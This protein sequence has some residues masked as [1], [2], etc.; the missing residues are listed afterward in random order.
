MIFLNISPL[1]FRPT[2][3]EIDLNA[4][5]HN[6][7]EF[8][9]IL[10][11]GVKIMAVVKADAYGHGAVEVARAMVRGGVDWFAVAFLEEGVELRLAGIKTPILLIGPTPPEQVAA[12]I[13]Y[14]LTQTIFSRET[15]AALSLEAVKQRVKKPVHVK[16]DTGMGRVGIAPQDTLEF[17]KE[18]SSYPGITVEGLLTHLASADEEDL[19]YT[20]QQIKLFNETIRSCRESGIEIPLIHAANSAGAINVMESHYNLVRLGLS[21]Y[22]H[23]PPGKAIA[24]HIS[25]QPALSFKT[26]IVYLKEVPA[27]AS[28]SYGGTFV[29]ER[30][31]LIATVPVGYADGYNR[32]LSNRGRVLVKGTRVPVVGRVC[33][34]Y[35]MVDVTGVDGV[36]IGD[37]VVL[38]G[39]Q[40]EEEVTVEEVATQLDTI[41]YEL[42]CAVHKRVSRFYMEE[43][44]V[45]S[46]RNLLGRNYLADGPTKKSADMDY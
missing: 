35:A 45:V 6:I 43:D 3:T 12:V 17:I 46:F 30:E 23:Y 26:Q 44:R 40:G 37:E 9:R 2:W 5:I 28:V 32:L 22:G 10:P 36:R 42:L 31:S 34:D 33:M 41:P 21:I 4:I 11:S 1:S 16:I 27:G 14:N 25:L 24:D 39:R 29:T 18:I 7:R 38:Y 20:Y 15:A 8:R 19:S 13:K